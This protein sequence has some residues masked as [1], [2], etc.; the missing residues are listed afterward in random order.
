MW[1]LV[2]R[3]ISCAFLALAVLM[4]AYVIYKKVR[5]EKNVLADDG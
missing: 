3:P 1:Q 5:R 2:T 4:V